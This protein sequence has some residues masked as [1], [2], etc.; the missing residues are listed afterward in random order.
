MKGKKWDSL[1]DEDYKDFI[2]YG[3]YDVFCLA[4]LYYKVEKIIN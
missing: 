4:E 2:E 3:M 1:S